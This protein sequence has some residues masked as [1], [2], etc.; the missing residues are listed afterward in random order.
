MRRATI[1]IH[2]DLEEVLDSYLRQQE[3]SPALTSVVQAAL[4][5]YLAHRGFVAEPK[6]FRIT[7]AKRGSGSRDTSVH[8]DRYLAGK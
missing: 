1:T 6:R 8:H 3:V 5:E 4:K 2:D 7:P